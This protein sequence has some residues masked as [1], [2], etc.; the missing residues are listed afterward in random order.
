[1]P[2]MYIKESEK[3][4]EENRQKVGSTF[5]DKVLPSAFAVLITILVLLLFIKVIISQYRI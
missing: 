4:N 5:R 2:S 3:P 1:M